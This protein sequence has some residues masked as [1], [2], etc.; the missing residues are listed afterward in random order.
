[1]KR[2]ILIVECNAKIGGIQKALISL[3][4]QINDVYDITL[5][6]LCRQGVLLQ[7]I[8]A[9]V[10]VLE[11]RSDFKYMGMAQADCITLQDKLLRGMYVLLSKFVG[12]RFAVR[13]AVQTLCRDE[14][15]EY[16]VAIAYSHMGGDHT[17]YAG[18]P[19]YVLHAVNAKKKVCY[20]HC[21]YLNSGNR[22]RYSDILYQRF[23]A[24]VCVSRSTRER[25]TLAKPEMKQR[26]F[27]VHNP[28]DSTSVIQQ[29]KCNTVRY[30]GDYLN[31]VS[32]ARLTAEKGIARF[33]RVISRIGSSKIK[34]WIVG[35]GPERSEIER[36][37]TEYHLKQMVTLCG[38]DANPYR[39]MVNADLL[40]V[41]SYHEAAPVVFQEAKVLGV[42][43]FTTRT[44]S[45]DEMVGDRFGF[46]VDNED[47]ALEKGLRFLLSQTER[48]YQKREDIQC[49]VKM[50]GAT[51]VP[52]ILGLIDKFSKRQE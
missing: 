29:A 38:E 48:I 14:Q 28:I 21:D 9:N 1:M 24:I 32:V 19:E 7:D 46:V 52:E 27:A 30:D 16:D 10:R 20:I 44:T 8:P 5:L 26:V 37:I 51:Q 15:E 33:V 41:P 43:V 13:L 6:L 2:R 47:D 35:D 31:L 4:K 36:L 45:A 23:H 49:L 11:T 25:F 22:S 39:Y 3:L 17:F 42:P 18:A 34:Y 50:Q 40:V 12:R